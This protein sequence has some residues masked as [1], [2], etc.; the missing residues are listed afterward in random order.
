MGINSTASDYR[1]LLYKLLPKGIAW[2][3]DPGSNL[4][5]LID[6]MAQEFSR[7]DAM[8]ETLIEEAFPNTTNQLLPE[9]ERTV[10]LPDKC[11]EI[12]ESTTIRRLNVLA[13]LAA[14]GGQSPQYFIDVAAALG[15]QITITEFN[16]FRA[17]I[18]SAG[19]PVYDVDWEYA[20]QVNAP[21]TTIFYFEAGVSVAGDPLADWGNDRL[22][23]VITDLKPAHTHVIFAYE[24]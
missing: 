17:D 20:W 16:V 23:C 19:D 15:Y 1:Q 3:N 4:Y 14:R 21:E 5:A 7:A 22:E 10:G 9:W 8:C 11:S 13:K 24:T 6:A 2:N 18:S 12:G